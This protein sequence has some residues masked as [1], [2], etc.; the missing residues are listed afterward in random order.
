MGLPVSDGVDDGQIEV[1]TLIS[2]DRQP[3]SGP[4]PSAM[5]FH[6][7]TPS[8]SCLQDSVFSPSLDSQTSEEPNWD[9]LQSDAQSL[10][11]SCSEKPS[12]PSCS[13]SFTPASNLKDSPL[14]PSHLKMDMD[15]PLALLNLSKEDSFL[16]TLTPDKPP[17][18]SLA[19]KMSKMVIK[20][21]ELEHVDS[22]KQEFAAA[23]VAVKE[24]PGQAGGDL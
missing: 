14:L 1:G 5:P 11:S 13:S 4:N 22:K 10:A 16:V 3:A 21:E 7:T 23:K 8:S 19:E 17:T 12:L 18:A 9:Q 24:T 2:V 15:S 20:G 6:L